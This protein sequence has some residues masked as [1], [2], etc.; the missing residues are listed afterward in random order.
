MAIR[1]YNTLSGKVDDFVP[2]TNNEVRFYTCGPTVYDFAHIGNY[3]TFVFQDV[4]R[5]HLKYRGYQVRQVMNLTD[6]DDKTIRNSQAA[7]M[8]LR[9]YTAKFIREFEI[10]CDLLNLEKPE[11][12][13]RATDHIDEMVKLIQALAQKGYA[14][15]SEG[16]EYFSVKQFKDYGKLSKIDF[17]GI[18]SGARVDSDE[19][20]K[21]NARD[22]VLWK[23][24]KEGEP[25]WETP[26]GPGRP[27]WHIEC[28]VMSMKYLGETFDIHSGGS[29]LVF[30]HHENE[31]AQSEA[32]TGKPFVRYWLHAEHLMV[33]GK[34][35]SKSEGNFFTLRDL[36]AKGYKPSA[37]RYLLASSH[38]R[39]PLN[40]TFEGLHQAQQSIQRLRNFRDRL[41][42]E[43]FPS[44]DALPFVTRAEAARLA[45]EEALDDNLN[46]AAAL[47]AVFDLVREGNTAIDRGEFPEGA[48]AAF[49]DV[50]ER[51]D[52]IFAVLDD[53]DFEK[54]QRFGFVKNVTVE[55][56]GN[57]IKSGVSDVK[58]E[59]GN[60]DHG[61]VLSAGLGENEIEERISA[62]ESARQRGEYAAADE[63]RGE[64]L[65]AGVILE[66]TK[67]GTRW[68]RK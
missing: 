33:D 19:Y 43:K 36:I 24:A 47:A 50:L 15:S 31:I 65:K 28:S 6:V 34:K 13:V 66:D 64:L 8:E 44:G 59:P 11:F 54:L 16:S 29:D 26:L 53:T 46:T 22:F 25:R 3:R 2:L 12:M 14:Y 62:R 63:I 61:A 17:S 32:A 9:D 48:R 20:E 30:P 49:L 57:V 37:I 7:G 38:F 58:V 4:L 39:M 1:F 60:G 23:A 45:F 56:T 51:W 18:R 27:G 41:T 52:R 42:M 10:D 35:M 40:F 21:D 67:A 5:R 68:K 55:V